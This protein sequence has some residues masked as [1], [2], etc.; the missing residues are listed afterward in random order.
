MTA[1]VA[2]IIAVVTLVLLGASAWLAR[3]GRDGT[4]RVEPDAFAQPEAAPWERENGQDL[5]APVATQVAPV[6]AE[7]PAGAR[8]RAEKDDVVNGRIVDEV[9]RGLQN[10]PPLPR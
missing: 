10:I 6:V 3:R 4:V 8:F 7:P 5:T 2:A 1:V 9:E